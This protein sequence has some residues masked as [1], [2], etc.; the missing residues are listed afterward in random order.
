MRRIGLI[1]T[2]VLIS[3]RAYAVS[4]DH[5]RNPYPDEVTLGAMT[6]ERI[7]SE[8]TIGYKILLG[9]NVRWC[10]TKL[11]VSTDG[12]KTFNFKPTSGYV[13]GDIGKQS[14]SG[15]KSI[16]YD[17]IAD[18]SDLAGKQ[19]VFKIDVVAKDVLKNEILA[20]AQVSMFP[21]LS[22]GFMFGMVK[23]YGWYVKARSDFKFISCSYGCMSTGEIDGGGHI[24]TDGT[25]KKTRLAVTAGGMIRA[26]RWCYPYVGLGYGYRN[27]YWKD[28]QG[29]WAKVSDR[30]CS[31]LSL[32]AGLAFKFGKVALILGVNN[33]AFKYTEAEVGIGVMF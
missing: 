21:Q 3:L 15:T 22:Y 29:E 6:V 16:K 10:K 17:V 4:D 32:D 30:S 9:D 24:W 1:V 7:G 26:S 27:L 18:K 28:F 11:L 8:F 20:S 2:C 23:K 5:V 19:L 31:G 13:T 33:T 12:G 25:S 14:T